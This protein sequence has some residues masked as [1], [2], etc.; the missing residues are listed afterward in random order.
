[1]AAAALGALPEA[2]AGGL[3]AARP[4]RSAFAWWVGAAGASRRHAEATVEIA[5]A[6]HRR[7]LEALALAQLARL[8]DIDDDLER[9][10]EL[11][12]RAIVLAEESGSREA[13]GFVRT[14]AARCAAEEDDLGVAES[15][16]REALAA[17]EE[18]G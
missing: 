10:R 4:V 12:Q 9:E 13:F 15:G 7:D 14:V 3:R 18:I 5:R 17:Y 16:Y 1:W 8:A 11:I 2:D 6:M